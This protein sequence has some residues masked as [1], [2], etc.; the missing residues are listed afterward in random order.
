LGN[1]EQEVAEKK[2]R[3]EMLV[4][5]KRKHKRTMKRLRRELDNM[6]A[7]DYLGSSSSRSERREG[8]MD[9]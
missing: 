4:K 9:G 6:D 2:E 5:S 3:M 8:E 7:G 1:A